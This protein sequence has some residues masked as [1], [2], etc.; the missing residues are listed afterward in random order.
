L[1]AEIPVGIGQY[2]PEPAGIFN[3]YQNHRAKKP[4]LKAG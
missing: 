1:T 4:Q 3:F 2:S